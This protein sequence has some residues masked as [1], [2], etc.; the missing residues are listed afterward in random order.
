MLCYLV[1]PK[2]SRERREMPFVQG[3]LD[4]EPPISYQR[5]QKTA[6][7]QALGTSKTT[8]VWEDQLLIGRNVL[9]RQNRCAEL[10][11]ND[12]TGAGTRETNPRPPLRCRSR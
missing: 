12:A 5:T 10:V 9:L 4:H 6:Y 3:F 11:V 8:T 2:K 1:L 7:V